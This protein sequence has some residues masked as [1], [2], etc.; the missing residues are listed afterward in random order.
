MAEISKREVVAAIGPVDDLIV[1]EALR[2]GA[3]QIELRDAL[4]FAEGPSNAD[5]DAY[6][7]LSGRMRR[8]VDL[9]SVA[10]HLRGTRAPGRA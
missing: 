4:A 9:L 1:R 2:T 10:I 5:A 7:A 3:S 6:Q 8:L